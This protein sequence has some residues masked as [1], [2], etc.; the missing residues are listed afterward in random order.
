MASLDTSGDNPLEDVDIYRILY[1]AI[2]NGSF[3]IM[4]NG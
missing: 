1:E 3:I 2:I 4:C